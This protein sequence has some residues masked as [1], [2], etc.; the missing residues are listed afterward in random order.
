MNKKEKPSAVSGFG[1]KIRFSLVL[2]LNLR[3][4]G[5]LLSAFISINLL[6]SILLF[7]TALW[8]AEAGAQKFITAYENSIE[9]MAEPAA[10]YEILLV[11]SEKKGL[12]LPGLLQSRLPLNNPEVRRWI[13]LPDAEP[14]KTFFSRLEGATYHMALT[15]KDTPLQIAYTLE[16]DL[17]QIYFILLIL[18]GSQVLYFIGRISTNNQVIRHTLKPLAE[19]VETAKSIHQDMSGAEPT[20]AGIKRLAGAISTINARELNR[21]LSI[22]TSQEEL[23][24]L[25]YAINDML[26]RIN[27]AYQSQV[28]FVADA[29]HELRTPLSVLQG[30]AN[31]LDR[32]GKHDEKTLQE[33]I[34]AIKSE[35]ENMKVLVEQLLFLARGDNNTIHLERVVF[36]AREIVAE[37]VRETRLFDP[38]HT[39][40]TE[41]EGP[42]YLE[43]DQ[44][45][46]KQALRILVDNSIKYTPAGGMIQLKVGT[47]HETVKI[48]VRDN[49]IGI[50]PDDVPRIFDRFYRSDESRARKTGGSGLGL[51]IAKWIIDHHG[52]H[53]EVLSRLGIGTRITLSF[54]A[55]RTPPASSEGLPAGSS[56]LDAE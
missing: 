1:E 26:Q 56:N 46:I 48:Q 17:R 5:M 23:K 27:Q 4:L 22:D 31:L 49:G 37:I 2:K 8:R 38:A 6:L 18:L 7:G 28:R 51:A 16:P 10:G 15:A 9:P 44:H 3:M 36:D 41:L 24:D 19:M 12:R 21:G 20:G 34:D 52:G 33:A 50:A 55:A 25:A 13:S 30:Y 39:F 32:W 43:A 40:Q 47:E 14:E 11:E 45:L 53:Y 54:P 42:A 35:T 29:S